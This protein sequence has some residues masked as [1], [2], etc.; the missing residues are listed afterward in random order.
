MLD[1]LVAIW[2]VGLL[3]RSRDTLLIAQWDEG[4]HWALV[5]AAGNAETARMHS[6]V[7]ERIRVTRRLDFI[8]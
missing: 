6:D 4:F 8:N 3:P 1:E 2:L 7:T 5:T